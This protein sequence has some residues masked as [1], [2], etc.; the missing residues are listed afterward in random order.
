MKYNL[1][2]I[3]KAFAFVF[4]LL[5]IQSAIA[6]TSTI[7]GTV[8]DE[9]GVPLPGVNIIEKNTTN[10]V[11][12]NFDGQY[13]INTSSSDATLVFSFIGYKTQEVATNGRISINVSMVVDE[14]QL[15]PVVV[16]GYGTQ[17]KSSITGAVAIVDVE[18]TEKSQYTN[19]VDRLQ[20]RVAVYTTFRLVTGLCL[21]A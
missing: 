4:L 20:G 15:D 5:G 21:C 7:N 9:N 14:N 2:Y 12:T 11:A 10:G 16:I 13:S 8:N 17:K 1:N 6:Q 3:G 18:E 19:V